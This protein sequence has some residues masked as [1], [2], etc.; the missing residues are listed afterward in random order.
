MSMM[1]IEYSDMGGAVKWFSGNNRLAAA[2][3][4]AAVLSMRLSHAQVSTI[5]CHGMGQDTMKAVD[6][7]CIAERARELHPWNMMPKDAIA[8]QRKLASQVSLDDGPTT[9][10]PRKIAAFDVSA[11]RFGKILYAAA[12]MWDVEEG[13]VVSIRRARLTAPFPYVPGLLSFREMPAIIEAMARLESVP[14]VILCDAQGIMHPR[15]FGLASHVGLATGIPTIGCAK[16]RLVGDHGE[17][18]PERGDR[19]AV[20][21]KGEKVGYVLRTRRTTKPLYV[22]PGHRISCERAVEIILS[23]H[24]GKRIPGPLRAAHGQ[25][26]AFM[27][28]MEAGGEETPD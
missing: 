7:V 6:M 5:P 15:L 23:L 22:S 16:S 4:P 26:V 13:H 3:L 18:G 20:T 27:R 28:S 9:D 10:H 25:S 14:D 24:D 17:P 12:V 1:Q 21:I 11:K 8:L 19:E 2:F